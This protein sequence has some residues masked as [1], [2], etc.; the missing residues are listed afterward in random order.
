MKLG[1]PFFILL[2]IAFAFASIALIVRDFRTNYPEAGN[3][4][5]ENYENKYNYQRLI[6]GS[7]LDISK[8]LENLQKEES[9]WKVFFQSLYI[10]PLAVLSTIAQLVLA[11]PYL[12]AILSSVSNDI[13]V[14]SEITSIALTAVIGAGMIMLV[15]FI[16]KSV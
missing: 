13:G 7:F 1:A 6:N 14:P 12:G 8:N 16:N 3:V 5:T 15:K 4:S 10:L 11:I 9:G 2:I